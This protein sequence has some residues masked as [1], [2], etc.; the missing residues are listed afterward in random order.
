[1]NQLIA[2]LLVGTC[3]VLMSSTQISSAQTRSTKSGQASTKPTGSDTRQ[4]G[5]R[6]DCRTES[7]GRC[8]CPQAGP[9]PDIS[10]S[11]GSVHVDGP[12]NTIEKLDS[13]GKLLFRLADAANHKVWDLRIL[14]A[15]PFTCQ[16]INKGITKECHHKLPLTSTV[17]MRVANGTP[18]IKILTVD[19]GVKVGL[20]VS[21]PDMKF[22]ASGPHWDS[23][24]QNQS[25][26]GV[27]FGSTKYEGLDKPM[28]D[29]FPAP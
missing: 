10:I 23:V 7:D 6:P 18:T 25:I 29:F 19:L 8:V 5:P 4:C 22:K 9:P 14:S 21:S 1:M 12:G 16:G 17:T 20:F 2:G 11:S 28:I 3:V 24:Q 27:S 26:T 15:Q 13:D